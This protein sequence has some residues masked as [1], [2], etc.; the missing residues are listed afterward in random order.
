MAW[1][2]LCWRDGGGLVISSLSLTAD[3]AAFSGCRVFGDLAVVGQNDRGGLPRP[4]RYDG[5]FYRRA[6]TWWLDCHGHIGDVQ[7]RNGSDENT[8]SAGL[9]VPPCDRG[10]LCCLAVLADRWWSF[11]GTTA[12]LV[13]RHTHDGQ[14]TAMVARITPKS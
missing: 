2:C 7:P 10:S 12:K 14:T 5:A 13:I 3:E 11:I 1:A 8:D 9:F 6:C 4:R